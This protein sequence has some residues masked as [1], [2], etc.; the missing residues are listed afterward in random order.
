MTPGQCRA[1][2]GLLNWTQG[3][4]AKAA[5]VSDVTVRNFENGKTSLQP[6]SLSV[7]RS[8]LENAGVRFLNDDGHI[9]V[10]VKR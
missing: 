5:G 10:T 6:A 1:A 7:I 9:G 2:R 3:S 8:A 4:L